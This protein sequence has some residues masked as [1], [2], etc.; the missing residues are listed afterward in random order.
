MEVYDARCAAPSSSAFERTSFEVQR[1]LGKTILERRN[2]EVR[3]RELLAELSKIETE[4]KDLAE[5][6]AH[7]RQEAFTARM[8]SAASNS[9]EKNAEPDQSCLGPVMF[10]LCRGISDLDSSCMDDV[11]DTTDNE[12]ID[13]EITTRLEEGEEGDT[14]PT[15]E[16]RRRST[17]WE[18]GLDCIGIAKC[19]LC[20]LKFPLDVDAIEQHSRECELLHSSVEE[21]DTHV[22]ERTPLRSYR[23][24]RCQSCGEVFELDADSIDAHTCLTKERPCRRSRRIF[25]WARFGHVGFSHLKS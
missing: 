4:L 24:G 16:L 8:L 18:D 17:D 11:S 3:Q 20:G 14:K 1:D 12:Y 23:R 2:S 5:R 6:E 7:L 10:E 15:S 13:D 22:D 9:S 21:T 19:R 25:G